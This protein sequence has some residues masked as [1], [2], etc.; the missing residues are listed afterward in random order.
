[1]SEPEQRLTE[2]EIALTHQQMTLDEVSELV[3]AQADHIAGL[4]RRLAHLAERVEAAE[5]ALPGGMPEADRRPPH[6]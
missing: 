1:M 2:L 4:T 6:W 3:R 5:A